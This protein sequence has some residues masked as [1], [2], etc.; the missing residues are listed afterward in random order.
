MC[1]FRPLCKLLSFFS[2]LFHAHISPY[3]LQIEK[4][5]E[6]AQGRVWTGKQ[7]LEKGLVDVL[8][9][10]SQ[11]LAIAKEKAGIPLGQ[12]VTLVEF[13]RETPSIGALLSGLGGARVES[14][15]ALVEASRNGLQSSAPQYRMEAFELLD[16]GLGSSQ[17]G[18]DLQEGADVLLSMLPEVVGDLTNNRK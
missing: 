4:L 5:E 15:A 16:S 6:V 7:A 12:R 14:L 9:G 8:G 3:F 13:S 18:S 1:P 10:F 2:F 11:A 17:T